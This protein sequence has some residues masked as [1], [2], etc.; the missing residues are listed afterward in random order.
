MGEE[1]KRP[2]EKVTW[3]GHSSSAEAAAR[4]ARANITLDE[5]IQ[6]IQT[7]MGHLQDET[8]VPSDV[9]IEQVPFYELITSTILFPCRK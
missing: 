8:I 6:Q 3:D 7:I 1:D 2:E 5:Q 4:L 9:G